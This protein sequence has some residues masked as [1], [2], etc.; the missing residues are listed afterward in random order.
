LCLGAPRAISILNIV[1]PMTLRKAGLQVTPATEVN[2]RVIS[3]MFSPEFPIPV[4]L[5]E[6]G[7]IADT[8]PLTGGIHNL[9]T[10]PPSSAD[11]A[12]A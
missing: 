6:P 3:T 4:R 1:L 2:G 7:T 9:V 5:L 12:A 8:S 10:L 11:R